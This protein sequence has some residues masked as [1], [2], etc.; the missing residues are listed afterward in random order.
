[1]SARKLLEAVKGEP[2]LLARLLL[3]ADRWARVET[4]PVR[5]PEQAHALFYPKLAGL[6]Y[7][8]MWCL[9]LDRRHRVLDLAP[10]TQGN[11]AFTIVDPRQ[12]LRW[13]LTRGESGAYGIVLAHNHPSGDATPSPQDK[14]I[15]RRMA[16]AGEAVGL[17]LLDHLVVAERRYTSLAELGVIKV[18]VSSV[19]MVDSE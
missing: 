7:E 8:Q 9:A 18:P 10:M 15:T 11:D 17:F 1:M 4:G 14:D 6:P 13:A 2:E 12:I 16:A 19:Y 5:K 3:V